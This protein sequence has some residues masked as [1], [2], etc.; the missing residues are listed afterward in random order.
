[1]GIIEFVNAV[2]EIL[3]SGHVINN[4]NRTNRSAINAKIIRVITKSTDRIAGGWFV[5]H[6]YDWALIARLDSFY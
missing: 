2:R 6:E 5:N 4:G 1:M 3:Q